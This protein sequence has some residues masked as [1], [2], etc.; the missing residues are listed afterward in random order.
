M[1]Y[2]FIYF[3]IFFIIAAIIF[4]LIEDQAMQGFGTKMVEIDGQH[5][6]V[7]DFGAKGRDPKVIKSTGSNLA[8]E[9]LQEITGQKV[10]Y[11]RT[12]EGSKSVISGRPIMV[13]CQDTNNNIMVDYKPREFFT[14]N[15][16][17]HIN[18]DVY[19]FYDRLALDTQKKERIGALGHNYI[20][21]PYLVDNCVKVNNEWDCKKNIPLSLRKERI[22]KYLKE[23]IIESF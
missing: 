19:E 11:N 10:K 20:E 1:L 16:P 22:K 8:C 6:L 5:Y 23:K 2:N 12:I 7:P 4:W 15:G 9:S 3:L 13:D 18:N 14:F 17:D 21:I